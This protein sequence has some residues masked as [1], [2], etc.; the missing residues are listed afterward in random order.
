MERA[1]NRDQQLG[2]AARENGREKSTG[3]IEH[4][5]IIARDLI[6]DQNARH[7]RL[8]RSVN[9]FDVA[10]LGSG[11]LKNWVTFA[12]NRIDRLR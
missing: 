4:G 6:R 8:N 3:L 11:D 2:E 12:S 5:H 10:I 7:F 9:G 1:F